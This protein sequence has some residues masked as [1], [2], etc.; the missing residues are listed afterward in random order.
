MTLCWVLTK[1]RPFDM[2][3]L[4]SSFN[5]LFNTTEQQQMPAPIS[6]TNITGTSVIGFHDYLRC[7]RK[8]KLQV[9]EGLK[10]AWRTNETCP[11]QP[12]NRDEFCKFIGRRGNLMVVGDSINHGLQWS[13]VNSLIKD[14][15]AQVVVK[16]GY[17]V[18]NTC[19][20]FRICGDVLGKDQEFNVAFIRNDRLSAVD[21]SRHEGGNFFEWPWTDYI[22]KWK[23]KILV[24]N[25]GAHYEA[26]DIVLNALNST[27]SFIK[28][29]HPELLVF[30]R[31]TPPGHLNC[32]KHNGPL[33]K[34]QNLSSADVY[35]WGDFQ[36]QN[37]LVKGL[38]E[39]F[40]FI[41]VDAYAMLSLRADGHV[42]ENDCLHY[43]VPGPLDSVVE[44]LYN[45]FKII[46]RFS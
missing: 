36:R 37:H 38:V 27:F 8:P 16:D 44:L 34:R 2:A 22:E 43:C 28:E 14:P 40:G 26:D 41:F 5:V 25:R 31:D 6:G 3:N 21:R 15:A 30:F 39:K 32:M 12:V 11:T 9:R 23:V 24:L 42:H 18:C 17:P 46:P 35:N 10:W 19:P 1:P 4:L 33:E 45:I 29:R 13:I 7:M 20:G